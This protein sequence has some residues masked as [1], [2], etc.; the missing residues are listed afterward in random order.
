LPRPNFTRPW[1]IVAAPVVALSLAASGIAFAAQAR[2]DG[3]YGDHGTNFGWAFG[4][5]NAP[6]GSVVSLSGTT[7]TVL[8]FDGVT[9]KFTVGTSTRYFLN[10]KTATSAAVTAGLNVVVNSG[11]WWANAG[12]AMTANSVYLFSPTVLGNIQTVSGS[13]PDLTITVNNPQGFGFTITTSSTTKYWVN[14]TVTTTAPTFTAGEIIAALGIVT[15]TGSDTLAATQV[16]VVPKPPVRTP[17]TITFTSTPPSNPTVG[18]T[19]QV[20]ATG[21]PS[22]NPVFFLIDHSS[23]DGACSINH[24]TNTVSFKAAGTCTIDAFQAGNRSYLSATAQQSLTIS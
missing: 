16:N 2:H 18:G 20:T 8:E 6:L 13:A 17:Q 4:H 3:R 14:G 12:G 11:R 9:Q 21:G 23:T 7:L 24:M 10:G 19:Y 1:L 5:R 22:G 15:P